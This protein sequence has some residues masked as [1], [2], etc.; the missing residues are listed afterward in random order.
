MLDV[1]QKTMEKKIFISPQG[2]EINIFSGSMKMSDF[3]GVPIPQTMPLR[4]P[5]GNVTENIF[6]NIFRDQFPSTRP[7]S[8]EN[9]S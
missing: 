3:P 6:K 1:P 7:T 8:H 9:I 4:K 2:R 5:I